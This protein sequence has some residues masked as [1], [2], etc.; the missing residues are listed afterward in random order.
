VHVVHYADL[1]RLIGHHERMCPCA[2][3]EEPNPLEKV[4]ARDAGRREHQAVAGREILGH[5]QAVLLAMAHPRP[6]F[7]LLCIPVAEPCLDL[8][9]EAAQRAG[10]DDTL[11]RTTDPHHGLGAGARDSPRA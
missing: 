6:A 5:A 2:A 3:T 9:A 1:L 4:T 10:R 7:A 8:A 11:W